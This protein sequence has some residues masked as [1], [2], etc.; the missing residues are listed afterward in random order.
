MS[1]DL[2]FRKKSY[3]I[4]GL[5]L[6]G[7][8]TLDYLKKNKVKDIFLW[9][10]NFKKRK[11]FNLKNN[12][13]LFEKMLDRVDYIIISPGINIEDCF[14][15]KT[16]RRNFYKIITDIDLF[17]LSLH[18]DSFQSIVVTGTNGKSTFCKILEHLLKKKGLDVKVGGNIG[19][20]IL[21]LKSKQ[22]TIVIIE[23][24]SFQLALSK[25]IKPK[26]AIIL[27]ITKD[28][29]DWHRTMSNYI[30]SKLKVF[31]QQDRQDFAFIGDKQIIKHYKKKNFLGKLNFHNKSRHQQ[32]ILK[33]RNSYLKLEMNKK[34]LE[35]ILSL[36][37]FFNISNKSAIKYL[38]S[39]K[40]LPHRHEEFFNKEKIKFINDSKATSFES[41]KYALQSNKNIF[42]ILGGLPKKQDKII[43]GKLKSRIIKA[44]I[45]GKHPNFFKKQLRHKVKFDYFLSLKE[46]MQN[47][48]LIL[49]RYNKLSTVLLS[50]A[51]ASYDQ[52]SNFEERGEEF[53]NLV[54][55]YARKH[56]K[57]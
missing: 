46:A 16:L 53:K 44:F 3:A 33:I 54:K 26:Y 8:S 56:L 21:K 38:N 1:L 22:K 42:W 24:S 27:N 18:K 32:T 39:F 43:L 4:Y 13:N 9:D 12:K 31:E 5:G 36:S 40:G 51:S 34:N 11:F 6:T 49:K 10:D 35:L 57:N 2:N 15:K 45:I 52:Y 25:F 47:I 37:K 41:T 30:G 20:P 50:P 29:L 48:F 19:K 7:N 55:K 17:F 23:A 28:H 14:F